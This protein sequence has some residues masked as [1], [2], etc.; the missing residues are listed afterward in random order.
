MV[1]YVFLNLQVTS[2]FQLLLKWS[3]FLLTLLKVILVIMR[4]FL[5]RFRLELIFCSPLQ[6]FITNNCIDQIYFR[7]FCWYFL[8][9]LLI[10]RFLG[11][12][13]V[14]SK[15]GTMNELFL[16]TRWFFLK[17]KKLVTQNIKSSSS[18][19]VNTFSSQ[20]EF[21]SN[22]HSSCSSS[23]KFKIQIEYEKLFSVDILK[24][25]IFQVYHRGLRL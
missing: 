22:H 24:K 12:S 23:K 16:T 6:S 8:D 15:G 25:I 1:V 4:L 18:S 10:F 20:V 9:L 2:V 14:F 19:H 7:C 13:D 17:R 5:F 3:P 21:P 11:G